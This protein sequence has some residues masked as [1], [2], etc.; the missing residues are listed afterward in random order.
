VAKAPALRP[1]PDLLRYNARLVVLNSYWLFVVP[2][3]ASQLILFWYMAMKSLI[4]GNAT[5]VART[6]E[7]AAPIFAAFLCAHVLAPEYR[8][9]LEDIVFS[10]PVPF[11]RTVL[12]RLA[13]MYVF[14][15]ALIA[16]MLLV[17]KLALNA[18]YDLGAV[19][20]AGLPSVFFLSML[21]LAVAA[22]WHSP[23]TGFAVAAAVWAGDALLGTALNP[24]LTL[25]AYANKLAGATAAGDDMWTSKGILCLAGVIL[26][27]IAVR[28]VGRP[29]GPIKWRSLVKTGVAIVCLLLIYVGSGAFYKMQQLVALETNREA[30]PNLRRTHQE[31]FA[32]YGKLPVAYL[33][34][35]AYAA[36]IGYPVRR[37]FQEWEQFKG[38]QRKVDLL[39]AVV[40]GHPG[41][42]WADHAYYELICT[43]ARVVD[44]KKALGGAEGE[45]VNRTAALQYC[46]E[47]LRDYANSPFGPLVAERM[48]TL[49][50]T[51]N[52]EAAMRAAF[53]LLVTTYATDPLASETADKMMQFYAAQGRRDEAAACAET[54]LKA[55]ASGGDPEALIRIGDFLRSLG[56]SEPAARAYR[57]A[58][59]SAR[60]ARQSAAAAVDPNAPDVLEQIRAS[61]KGRRALKQAEA[62]L[63]EIGLTP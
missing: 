48:V 29:A 9:R 39:R 36:Y 58:L 22:V 42:R 19:V 33:F 14:L 32:A 35:P 23:V 25:H 26:A 57:Q 18:Q 56:R 43:A 27:S 13:T 11:A 55:M 7:T 12:A 47:F 53:T 24:L 20:L 1:S 4:E 44:D 15:A 6:T 8:H 61:G 2:L 37:D 41:S 63:R 16:A 21:A 45:L 49:A 34:S 38:R 54:A 30:L 5:Y 17:Y 62:K 52:D 3:V 10:R 31:A 40:Y 28:A 60:A 46:R 51:M 50:R 59:L